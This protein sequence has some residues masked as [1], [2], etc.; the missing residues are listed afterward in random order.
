MRLFEALKAGYVPPYSQ[1]IPPQFHWT[2]MTPETFS[3]HL[4]D[5]Q[6]NV[7][8]VLF[9]PET[10]FIGEVS[11]TRLVVLTVVPRPRCQRLRFMRS[12]TAS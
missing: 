9:Q 5:F 12:R 2:S 10:V 7:A 6:G 8:G 4:R 11:A 1:K 3:V